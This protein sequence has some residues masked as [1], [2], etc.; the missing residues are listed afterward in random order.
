MFEK[1]K[2]PSPSMAVAWLALAVALGGTAVAA[3]ATLVKL[4]D[5][6]GTQIA[7]ID[8]LSRLRTAAAPVAPA[9]SFSA[10]TYLSAGSTTT[11]LGPTKAALV[12]STIT[13]GNYYDQFG[14][15]KA[16][17]VVTRSESSSADC[18]TYVASRVIGTYYV[19]AGQTQHVTFP[20][21]VVLKPAV[22]G[23]YVC[24][25]GSAAIQGNPSSYYLPE[26]T[27]TGFVEGGSFAAPGFAP[28]SAAEADGAPR[29]SR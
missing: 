4:T 28:A 22:S 21:G 9:G 1:W 8:F 3:T 12:L 16:R 17:I 15:A 2:L 25:R 14:A 7:D 10:F 5:S 27:A 29:R 24:L 20:A 19:A 18:S 13:V 11:I 6:S 26:I 23:N